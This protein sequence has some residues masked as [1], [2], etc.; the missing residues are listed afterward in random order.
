MGAHLSL[1]FML[2]NEN[3]DVWLGNNRGT[4][5]SKKHKTLDP[6]QEKK[7]FFDFSFEEIGLYDL[8]AT[9]DYILNVT[10]MKRLFYVGYSQ[11]TTSFFLMVAAKPEYNEKVIMMT[12]LAPVVYLSNVQHLLVSFTKHNLKAIQEIADRNG[13]YEIFPHTPLMTT[14]ADILCHDNTA[15]QLICSSILYLIGGYSPNLNKVTYQQE[16]WIKLP[17]V[18]FQTV[19]PVIYGEL[20]AGTSTKTLFHYI[21][22]A[23]AGTLLIYDL[24]FGTKFLTEKFQMYDYGLTANIQRY[25]HA[26]PPKFNISKITTPISLYYGGCD[27]LST[28]PVSILFINSFI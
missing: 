1:G 22:L 25:G 15:T 27:S 14:Y 19:L 21:Q 28:R 18:L 20:P 3:F 8:T 2:A 24:F 6:V 5:W 26:I 7:H 11:G 12:A 17:F 9:I 4:T 10:N 13:V 23:L 16:L